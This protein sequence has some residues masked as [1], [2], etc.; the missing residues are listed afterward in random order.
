MSEKLR[1]ELM[2]DRKEFQ[3]IY[4]ESF[5]KRYEA[6]QDIINKLNDDL[7]KSITRTAGDYSFREKQ[8]DFITKEENQIYKNIY[9]ILRAW[10]IC[11]IKFDCEMPTEHLH[12]I[13]NKNSKRELDALK[14]IRDNIL[15]D[16]EFKEILTN[17]KSREIISDYISRFCQ[18]IDINA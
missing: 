11:S 7:L 16:D 12:R 17:D 3:E 15:L 4:L 8:N 1:H 13:I 14:Y 18:K 10:L 5:R 6:R 9:A 2:K